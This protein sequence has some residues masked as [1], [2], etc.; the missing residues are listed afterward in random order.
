MLLYEWSSDRSRLDGGNVPAEL[1]VLAA[2]VVEG[3]L[4]YIPNQERSSCFNLLT[5][6]PCTVSLKLDWFI[7]NMFKNVS[8][9]AHSARRA[10]RLVNT[11][12]V[13]QDRDYLFCLSF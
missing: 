7:S 2:G 13:L 12:A 6:Q 1:I 3:N 9:L 11:T 4:A 5:R 8:I 10:L